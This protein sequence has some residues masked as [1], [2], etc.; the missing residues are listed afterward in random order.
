M[1]LGVPESSLLS[2][3]QTS[4]SAALEVGGHDVPEANGCGTLC[5]IWAICKSFLLATRRCVARLR[6]VRATGW[7][8]SWQCVECTTLPAEVFQGALARARSQVARP[9]NL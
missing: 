5:G 8:L 2:A 6:K 7:E 4:H 1:P 9:A 3:P